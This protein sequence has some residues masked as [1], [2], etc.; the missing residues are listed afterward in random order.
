MTAVARLSF[1]VPPERVDEFAAVYERQL[2]PLLLEHGLDC[3]YPP[4]R[5]SVAGVFSRLFDMAS[6]ADIAAGEKALYE[7]LRWREELEALGAEFGTTFASTEPEERYY[8][9]Y[10]SR[11]LLDKVGSLLRYHFWYYQ[12]MAGEGKAI[13]AGPGIHKGAWHNY[14]MGDGLPHPIVTGIAEDHDGHIWF[15][16][17]GKGVCR[18]N[19]GEFHLFGEDDGLAGNATHDIL[20]DPDGTMWIATNRGLCQ[21]DGRQFTTYTTEDGLAGNYISELMV[22]SRGNLWLGTFGGGASRYDGHC[23]TNFTTREGLAGNN[24]REIAE[25]DDG[26]IWFGTAANGACRYDGRT[27]TTITREDGLPDD[28]VQSIL[29]D[30]WGDIWFGSGQLTDGARGGVSRYD[31]TTLTHYEI[32][33]GLSFNEVLYILQDRDGDLWFCRPLT[34][35]TRYDGRTFHTYRIEDGFVHTRAVCAFEDR[36]GRL[37]F[38]T[39]GGGVGCYVKREFYNYTSRDGLFEDGIAKIIEDRQ[40]GMW[41]ITWRG[42]YKMEGE[43]IVAEDRLAGGRIFLF[44]EDRQGRLWLGLTTGGMTCLS[45]G[46]YK[47]YTVDDGL[48]AGTIVICCE[49]RQG[50]LWFG[51]LSGGVSRF[52]EDGFFNLTVADGLGEGMVLAIGEDRDG[53]MWF[54]TEGGASRYDGRRISNFTMADGLC[55]NRINSIVR[56]REEILWFGGPGGVNYYD[57]KDFGVLDLPERRF[58]HYVNYIM[59]DHKG[60]LWFGTKGS[61]IARYDGLVMQSLSQSDGLLNDEITAIT[62]DRQGHMWIGTAGGLTRYRPRDTPPVVRF[63]GIIA[64]RDYGPVDEL[65]ISESQQ[66]IAFDF[67]GISWT[68]PT[69]RM[70]YVHRLVNYQHEWRPVYTGRAEYRDLPVGDYVF[71]VKAVDRDLNYSEPVAVRV[72]VVRDERDRQIDELERRVQARTLELAR[73]NEQLEWQN[74]ALAEANDR[75]QEADRLKSD[76]VSNVSHELRT[77]LTVIRGS[78][79]NMLDGIVGIFDERQGHY[80]SRLKV[81]ADRLALLIDDLLDLS[82]IEAGHLQIEKVKASVAGIAGDVVEHLQPLA[83]EERIELTYRAEGEGEALVDPNR[84]YQVLLNL[85]NNAIKF[86]PPGGEV[87]VEAETRNGEVSVAVADTGPGI[88]AGELEQIFEKFH[89]VGEATESYRGAGIGLSIARRLVE[90]HG[91]AIRVASEEGRGS[92]FTLV[93]PVGL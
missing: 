12:V 70:V 53:C 4:D 6:A 21:Y 50:N 68:T 29:Q 13:E 45:E 30:R 15:A 80:V 92:R 26:R 66:Y 58:H 39:W 84:V 2:V 19:G 76:F 71:E 72:S 40:G 43:R 28:R 24:I 60:Y 49:D 64:D 16:M 11:S 8:A 17:H 3:G 47:D 25:D 63:K 67:I 22:D 33:E 78:V 44:H 62:Q 87:V 36:S 56:D 52:D 20:T 88:P 18:Y 1:W 32:E 35:V 77:P 55:D 91:G 27:F 59:E 79:D 41:F 85:V 23:F 89:Q 37:W 90:M 7:D 31:G 82:R 42:L 46:Q 73:A 9:G 57:G 51:S 48:V 69:D 83:A 54:G 74:Q 61:G 75:L 65:A 5:A 81:H 10:F 14:T 38:G 34:G 93:L 86:T